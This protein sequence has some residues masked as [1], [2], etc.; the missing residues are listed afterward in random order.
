M[1]TGLVYIRRLYN[2]IEVFRGKD[3]SAI[4]SQ[5]YPSR[6]GCLQSCLG[7]LGD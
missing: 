5:L 4:T 1:G 6:L 2:A 7:A 3:F